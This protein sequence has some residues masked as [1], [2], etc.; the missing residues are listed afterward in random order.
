VH[1]AAL[2]YTGN[3]ICKKLSSDKGCIKYY[4]LLHNADLEK[5]VRQDIENVL[6]NYND[7]NLVIA[8]STLELGV[9]IP[10]VAATLQFGA[11]PSG[12]S[13]VQRVGRSGR[14]NRSLRIAFGSVFTRNVGKDIALIDETEAI[15]NLFN[16][17]APAYSS[18][19]DNETLIRYMALIYLDKAIKANDKIIRAILRLYLNNANVNQI[20]NSAIKLTMNYDELKKMIKQ[21]QQAGTI[22]FMSINKNKDIISPLSSIAYWLDKYIIPQLSKS[23]V[24]N[25]YIKN[26]QNI[27][28]NL[29][30]LIDRFINLKELSLSRYLQYNAFAIYKLLCDIESTIVNNN[31]LK[32][33]ALINSYISMISQITENIKSLILKTMVSREGLCLTS[34]DL[35]ELALLLMGMPMPHPAVLSEIGGCMFDFDNV[36]IRGGEIR[37]RCNGKCD[38]S[39]GRINVLSNVPLKH[40]GE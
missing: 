39:M 24:Q 7:W 26:I 37:L 16:L 1:E 36:E 25:Q 35:D 11:P 33:M 5:D 4:V 30:A 2:N 9:N 14:D 19:P 17:T 13:F 18:E 32:S 15:K 10:G 8:T 27:Q 21:H 40:Y 29:K 23:N 12:E 28:D 20:L 38:R 3:W 22:P 31:G 34:R 6:S